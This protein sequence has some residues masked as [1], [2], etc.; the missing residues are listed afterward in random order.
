MHNRRSQRISY[1]TEA[2]S[3]IYL[4]PSLHT[5]LCLLR[6]S[7]CIIVCATAEGHVHGCPDPPALVKEH[8]RHQVQ[9]ARLFRYLPALFSHVVTIA[10]RYDHP[11]YMPSDN[12]GD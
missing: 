2:P 3:E 10:G 1:A 12:F 4:F 6:V 7:E 9:G 8:I 5:D 11:K